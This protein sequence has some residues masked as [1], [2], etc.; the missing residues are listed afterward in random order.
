MYQLFA[1]K[2]N[3]GSVSGD[4]SITADVKSVMLV[5]QHNTFFNIMDHLAPLIRKQ[6]STSRSGRN[7]IWGKKQL[8]LPIASEIISLMYWKNDPVPF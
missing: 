1:N 8:L 7:F 5:V 4:P 6:I 2:W 3:V